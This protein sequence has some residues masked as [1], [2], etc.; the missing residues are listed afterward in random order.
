MP[1]PKPYDTT[2][3]CGPDNPFTLVNRGAVKVVIRYENPMEPKSQLF[4]E[5]RSGRRRI[6]T[7]FVDGHDHVTMVKELLEHLGFTPLV[8][9][10]TVDW[11]EEY[12]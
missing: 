9:A 4:L 2:I 10:N 6:R 7:A 12:D 1:S 11:D 8:L 3:N 5:L